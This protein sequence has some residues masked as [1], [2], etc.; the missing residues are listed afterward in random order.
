M[1]KCFQLTNGQDIMGDCVGSD[2]TV[3]FMT[4]D[5]FVMKNPAGIHMVP[6]QNKEGQFGIALIPFLPFAEDEKIMIKKDKIMI[7]YAPTVELQNNYSKLF[8]AG[9]QIANVIP[10]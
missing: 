1:I 5:E 3:N 7:S 9:I 4:G 10:R 6:S 8:G 2:S